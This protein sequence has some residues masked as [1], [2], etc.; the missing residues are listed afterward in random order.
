MKMINRIGLFVLPWFL[1]A[2]GYV[3]RQSGVDPKS[4]TTRMS[5]DLYNFI[6]WIDVVMAVGVTIALF[7]ALWK[8][9]YRGETHRPKQVHG[10]KLAEIS[11]TIAPV[12]ILI[13]IM[14]PT[15][16]T[17]FAQQTVP[18]DDALR[19]KVIG[20][21]WWWEYEYEKS[22][23]VV[24]NE[25]HVPVGRHVFLDMVSKDVIHAWWAPKLTGKRDVNSWQRTFLQFTADEPGTYWGQCTEYCGDSHALMRI[26]VVVQTPED[27]EKWLKHQATDV[28]V[29]PEPDVKA[30]LAQCGTCHS[31]RGVTPGIMRSA[32]SG[33]DLTHLASRGSL[34]SDLRDFSKAHLTEWLKDPRSLK[35]GVRMPGAAVEYPSMTEDMVRGVP[36]GLKQ[37]NLSNEMIEKVAD[38]L[39]SLK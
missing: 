30:A 16:E 3:N 18:P 15:V 39:A 28:V 13:A 10:H 14:V 17:I 8:F 36:G 26:K 38:Y 11:W 34:F 6:L 32:T 7:Y 9:R 35:P 4:D 25:L 2:C 21:Q 20:K 31:I 37:L 23:V 5:D 22:G 1:G 24:A 12:F 27:F 33:P 29:Q 19:I